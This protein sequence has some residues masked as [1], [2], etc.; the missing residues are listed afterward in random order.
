MS[1]SRLTEF[2]Y[3]VN[4]SF[5]SYVRTK[6]RSSLQLVLSVET[7]LNLN[8]QIDFITSKSISEVIQIELVEMVQMELPAKFEM[9]HLVIRAMVVHSQTR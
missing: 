1:L 5:I 4:V 2:F 6:Q 9:V 7:N 3:G 8:P